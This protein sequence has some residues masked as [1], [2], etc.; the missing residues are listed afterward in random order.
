M[1]TKILFTGFIIFVVY[2]F[3]RFRGRTPQKP[4]ARTQPAKPS[5]FGRFAAYGFVVVLVIVSSVIF[6]FQWQQAHRVVTIR[7]I[8]GSNNNSI[9]GNRFES[10]DGKFVVLGE[11]ER[12]EFIENGQ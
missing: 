5:A 10:L 9:K 12:V 2:A 7:V 8:D 11:A 3:Y 4:A 1:L 6:V